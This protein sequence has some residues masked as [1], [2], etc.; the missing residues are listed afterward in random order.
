MW[1]CFWATTALPQPRRP[2]PHGL[3]TLGFAGEEQV[4]EE[5]LLK[6]QDSSE[7]S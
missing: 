6:L 3:I 1:T 4:Q 5:A 2:A 7:L